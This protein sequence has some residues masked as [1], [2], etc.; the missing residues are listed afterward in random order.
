[1]DQQNAQISFGLGRIAAA[2]RAAQWQTAADAGLVPAQAEILTRIARHPMRPAEIAAHL[3]VSAASTSD[4]IS[5]LV[6]KGL[7]ER[8]PDPSDRRAQLL[9]P[10][11]RGAELAAILI[12][13]PS[14]IDEA[15]TSLADLERADLSRLL[16]VLIRGLQ[17]ARAIPVQRMCVTCRH[18][19]PR[20]H[21]DPDR[22]HHCEFVNAAFG[23]AALRLDCGEHEP[24]SPDTAADHWRRFRAA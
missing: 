13:A 10:T 23:D 19:R 5:T 8:R 17:D 7:A 22:P 16:T 15:L 12:E 1:M 3:G 21:A 11:V 24:A 20:V 4:S 14:T 9:F 6:A 2:Y 18:F